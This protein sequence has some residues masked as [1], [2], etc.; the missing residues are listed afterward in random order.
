M[1]LSLNASGIQFAT[2]IDAQKVLE[3]S[4]S[5]VSVLVDQKRA[6]DL[7]GVAVSDLASTTSVPATPKETRYL[8]TVARNSNEMEN[9]GFVQRRFLLSSTLLPANKK[10]PSKDCIVELLVNEVS[11]ISR[12]CYV[13]SIELSCDRPRQPP[14]GRRNQVSEIA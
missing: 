1:V 10:R 3:G 4:T 2:D 6:N 5:L 14:A 9:V 7:P 11:G 13:R 12:Q 8:E